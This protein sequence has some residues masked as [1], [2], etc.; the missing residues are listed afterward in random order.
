MRRK[1][2]PAGV[3]VC[4]QECVSVCFLREERAS[5]HVA[6]QMTSGLLP[7]TN[8]ASDHYTNTHAEGSNEV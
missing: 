6:D 5:T 7:P 1:K 3:G 4:V 8:E 2:N